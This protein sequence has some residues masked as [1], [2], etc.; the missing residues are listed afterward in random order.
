MKKITKIRIGIWIGVVL[1]LP[2]GIALTDFKPDWVRCWWEGLSVGVGATLFLLGDI[3]FASH[4]QK[5]TGD[6]KQ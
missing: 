1:L 5:E 3:I 2:I 4:G 6:N